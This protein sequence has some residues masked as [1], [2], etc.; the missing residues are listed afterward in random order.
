MA[1]P[2]A[3][4]FP[5]P[6][7]AVKATVDRSVFSAMASMKVRTDFAYVCC[8]QRHLNED[9][10]H[11]ILDR[12]SCIFRLKSP[13]ADGLSATFSILPTPSVIRLVLVGVLEEYRNMPHSLTVRPSQHFQSCLR[14][15]EHETI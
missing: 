13:L 10:R 7:E 8:H 1:S 5:L 14:E 6:R 12:S 11:N 2:K 15:I 9:T 3:A 4:D